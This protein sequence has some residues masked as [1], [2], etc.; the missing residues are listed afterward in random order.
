MEHS[1]TDS[2]ISLLRSAK[3][4]NCWRRSPRTL[5]SQKSEFST[6]KFS[7]PEVTGTQQKTLV[8]YCNLR[9]F[10]SAD[11]RPFCHASLLTDLSTV[12]LPV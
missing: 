4:F 7:P 11:G 6:R 2:D 8:N 10:V 3:F 1:D 12:L 5:G 9:G